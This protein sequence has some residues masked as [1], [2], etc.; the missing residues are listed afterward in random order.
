MEAYELRRAEM[1]KEVRA[2]DAQEQARKRAQASRDRIAAADAALT[3][4]ERATI[5]AQLEGGAAL[6]RKARQK[7]AEAELR[8]EFQIRKAEAE[9]EA[10]KKQKEQHQEQH[11][12]QHQEQQHLNP[13][14]AQAVAPAPANKQGIPS[15]RN[16]CAMAQQF[17]NLPS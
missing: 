10:R 12:K 7:D 9:A 8:R 15:F 3:P 13:A 11:Q 2:R 1:A 16:C 14:V 4:K 5:N 17:R 6:L